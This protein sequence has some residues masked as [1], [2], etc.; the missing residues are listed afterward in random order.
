LRAYIRNQ[1]SQHRKTSFE[2]E[3]DMM[4]REYGLE[5]HWD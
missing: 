4:I 3:I 5:K 2:D 1:V